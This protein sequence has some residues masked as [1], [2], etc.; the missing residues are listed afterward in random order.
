VG[1]N[2][3][4]ACDS[5]GFYWVS[6]AFSE[7]M[8]INRVCDRDYSASNVGMIN[9]LVNGGGNGYYERMAYS[10][11]MVRQL[12][13]SHENSTTITINPPAP[14]SAVTANMAKPE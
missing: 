11:Y 4:E 7:G 13:D 9:R 1:E 2:A 10:E 8:S 5:G 6:K 3:H 12:L 14:K